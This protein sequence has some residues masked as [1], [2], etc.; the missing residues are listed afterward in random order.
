[1]GVC[2]IGPHFGQNGLCTESHIVTAGLI[3][4]RHRRE[5]NLR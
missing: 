3:D 2:A 1:M 5:E 4:G